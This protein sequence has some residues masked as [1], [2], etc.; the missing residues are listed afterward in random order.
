MLKIIFKELKEYF[1]NRKKELAPIRAKMKKM[2]KKTFLEFK[3]DLYTS[4]QTWAFRKR[5]GVLEQLY[6]G[7]QE[8]VQ[9]L[10]YESEEFMNPPE[11]P[12]VLGSAKY[13]GDGQFSADLTE[14]GQLYFAGMKKDVGAEMMKWNLHD[15]ITKEINSDLNE[16]T[17]AHQVFPVFEGDKNIV[18]SMHRLAINSTYGLPTD[19]LE[20]PY[21]AKEY[22]KKDLESEITD[23][24]EIKGV[25][26]CTNDDSLLN[27]MYENTNNQEVKNY[28]LERQRNVK[29]EKRRKERVKRKTS[30]PVQPETACV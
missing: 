24:D 29:R 21:P 10:G 1:K 25:I 7:E 4:I 26:D 16:F 15:H 22:L 27:F 17:Y 9:S 28:I 5:Q 2:K 6:L 30:V 13:L 23:I 19:K 12:T 20:N 14:E 18:E 11:E 8:T 3:R